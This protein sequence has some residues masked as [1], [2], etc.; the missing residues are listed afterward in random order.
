LRIVALGGGTGLPAVL[1][2]LRLLVG[3]TAS[4][5]AITAVVAV[6]DDGGSSGALRRQFQMLPPGDIR[7]CIAALAGDASMARLLQHRFT[8]GDFANHPVGN[9]LLSALTQQYQ[10]D[11]A[12]AVSAL[13]R[14][15]RS[16]GTV[17][18]ATTD[19][20]HLRAEYTCGE[21]VVGESAIGSR[22]L[23]IRRLSLE[24]PVRPLP[25]VIAALVNAD[26]VIVGPGSLYT[27]ILPVLLVDGIAATI[28]GLNAQRI[29]VSNLM[30]EPG[31][32]D[33]YDLY[34]HVR[35]IR[36]H[37]G[38]DL[39]DH[40]VVNQRQ[41]DTAVVAHYRERGSV[42]VAAAAKTGTGERATIVPA[43]LATEH[44]GGKIRHEPV[45]LA[46]AID[47]IVLERQR[48]TPPAARRIA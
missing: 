16:G 42:P 22:R 27:S 44:A 47:R 36:E 3:P 39:F 26:V 2:A 35:A 5:N 40:I 23:P 8:E 10:G 37:T 14:I 18:P 24:R 29:Y 4:P 1:R 19:D 28:S 15:A 41:L 46:Q 32:T 13:S 30:T 17:L 25:E 9:L 21:V 11:F 48:E 6:T 31:E 43:D 38:A 20:V 33:G 34:D 45:S 7:N 12:S